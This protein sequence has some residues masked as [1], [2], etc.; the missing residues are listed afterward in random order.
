MT[1]TLG[2][3]RRIGA[4][5]PMTVPL[6]RPPRVQAIRDFVEVA[7]STTPAPL[8]A[9]WNAA[10]AALPEGWRIEGVML[11][12]TSDDDDLNVE[13]VEWE[14]EASSDRGQRSVTA[15]GP[16]P[17]AALL[18]LAEKLREVAPHE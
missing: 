18:A 4:K 12:D 11:V 7:I 15:L 2:G 5:K 13:F 10:E 3:G 8:D 14:A 9:A 6:R 17:A 1:K 16:T